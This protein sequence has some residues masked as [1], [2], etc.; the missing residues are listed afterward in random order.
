MKLTIKNHLFSLKG[1]SNV[2]DEDGNKVCRVKGKWLSFTK[3]KK[4][5]D[6]DGNL[7]YVVKN[8]MWHFV[9]HST[10][11]YDDEKNK[12]VAV[13]QKPFSFK[14]PYS[15]ESYTDDV[16]FTG[17]TKRFP[18]VNFDVEKNGKKIGHI[19]KDYDM[20]RDAFS[21]EVFDEKE[22]YF[23]VAIVIALDNVIDKS[24]KS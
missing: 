19:Q 17:E 13:I 4:I 21:V 22:I 3:K 12:V 5:L 7:Q 11:V 9:N 15:L 16:K 14:E 10:F 6:N 1:G 8:K 18:R 20:F 24:V 23:L 2:T